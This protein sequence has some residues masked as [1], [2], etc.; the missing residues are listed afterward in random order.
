M[1]FAL[2]AAML[3]AGCAGLPGVDPKS[4]HFGAFT[5][6]PTSRTVT[7]RVMLVTEEEA[8]AQCWR[9]NG[10]RPFLTA[11]ACIEGANPRTIWLTRPRDWQDPYVCA[12][13]HEVLHELGANHK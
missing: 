12:L 7:L 8:R 5:S 2:L 9:A 11:P 10:Y 1:R 3:C 6:E 4:P 13:G